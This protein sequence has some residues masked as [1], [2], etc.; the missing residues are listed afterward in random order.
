MQIT[1]FISIGTCLGC[2]NIDKNRRSKDD[3]NAIKFKLTQK[4]TGRKARTFSLADKTVL[5][6]SNLMGISQY[7]MNW[8]C[9]ST[10]CKDI[11]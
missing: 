7:S 3:S 6:K 2:T 8:F 10:V 4:L 5:M 9:L 11:D 1:Y